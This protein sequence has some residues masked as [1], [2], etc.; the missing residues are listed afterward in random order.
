MTDATL[1]ARPELHAELQ[2]R[3]GINLQLAADFFNVNNRQ[4]GYNFQPSVHDSTFN[5]PRDYFDPRRF[6]LAARFR[7]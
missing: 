7:F 2:S 3:A 6:Q 1:A 4:T 5:Q